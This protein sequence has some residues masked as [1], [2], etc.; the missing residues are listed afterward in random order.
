[1]IAVFDAGEPLVD[2]GLEVFEHGVGD[3]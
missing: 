1:M 3:G 2:V